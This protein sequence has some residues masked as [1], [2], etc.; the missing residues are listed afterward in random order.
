MRPSRCAADA[1]QTVSR[2][3]LGDCGLNGDKRRLCSRSERGSSEGAPPMLNTLLW[4]PVD[5]A[6]QVLR[7][8]PSPWWPSPLEPGERQFRP[9]LVVTASVAHRS[10]QGARE[11][12]GPLGLG[13]LVESLGP[14]G[15][16]Q[17]D[18]LHV[19]LAV[20][21]IAQGCAEAMLR[22]LMVPL[23]DGPKAPF[24]RDQ[25]RQS[26]LSQASVLARLRRSADDEVDGEAVE[27]EAAEPAGLVS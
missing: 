17:G 3:S 20:G 18:H 22:R 26:A 14:F 12:C 1:Q 11:H 27:S 8:L 23:Q 2:A 16:V 13:K 9:C 24:S 10:A 5:A 7:D 25:R 21:R 15:Q 4:K 6:D 19:V